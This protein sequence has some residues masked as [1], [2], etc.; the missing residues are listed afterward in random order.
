MK[1]IATLLLLSSFLL[2]G[3]ANSA[4][5]ALTLDNVTQYAAF[6][7]SDSTKGRSSSSSNDGKGTYTVIFDLYPTKYA[8]DT[9]VKGT[10]NLTFTPSDGYTIDGV[11]VKY[12]VVNVTGAALAYHA[13]GTDSSGNKQ[14][15]SL[16]G[17]FTFTNAKLP[18]LTSSP[19]TNFVFVTISGSLIGGGN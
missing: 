19:I 4:A 1:K 7:D 3:C 2:V 6:S 13:G 8:F 11:S 10:C 17:S 5:T 9:D 14:M 15:D 16:R 12:D 18:Q